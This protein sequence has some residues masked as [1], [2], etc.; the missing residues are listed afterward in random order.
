MSFFYFFKNF[1]PQY[2]ELASSTTGQ[3]AASSF[4]TA[5]ISE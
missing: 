3:V 1:T 5:N 4:L 2:F